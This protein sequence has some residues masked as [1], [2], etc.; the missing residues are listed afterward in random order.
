ME[1]NIMK[2]E[3]FYYD[4]DGFLSLWLCNVDSEQLLQDYINIDYEKVEKDEI[5]FPLGCDFNISWYDEDFIETA[6]ENGRTGWDLLKGHSY[7]ES[8]IPL[9]KK[10]Y[11]EVLEKNYNGTI[12]IYNLKY[13]GNV[14]E[15]KNE[16]YGYFKFIGSFPYSI[17]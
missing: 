11:Q 12:I 4:K 15:I 14:T 13:N 2:D 6:F 8:V 17:D 1:A 9:L 16:T 10:D 3:G 5:P 7:I